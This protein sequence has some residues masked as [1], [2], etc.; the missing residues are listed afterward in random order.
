LKSLSGIKVSAATLTIILGDFIP[1]T[2]RGLSPRKLH[3]TRFGQPGSL[4]DRAI[5]DAYGKLPLIFEVNRGQTDSRVKF[6]S[7]GRGYSLFL[8]SSEAV[9]SLH[10]SDPSS[11]PRAR[12][13][14]APAKQKSLL[15][16]PTPIGGSVVRIKLIGANTKAQVSGFDE[17][18]SKSN[19]FIGNYPKN[20]RINV[21]NYARVKYA[22]VYS[23]V[24]LVYYGNQRQLEYD[25]VL[26]AK[27]DPR[28][29]ELDF[30]G[31]NRLW[32]D[33]DGNLIVSIAG[34]EIIEHKPLIYQ[35]INGIR[36]QVAGGY[37]LKKGQTVGFK[38]ARYDNHRGLTIDP[39]LVYST[40]LG[41]SNDDFGGGVAVDS[42]GNAYV[43]GDTFSTDFPTTPRAFQTTLRGAENGWCLSLKS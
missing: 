20:W 17:L 30:N 32:L 23:G 43:A 13:G 42:A 34:G 18:S 12:L 2:L 8:T 14:E 22:S 24:D 38:L 16:K 39:G 15:G 28:Q 7:R 19:Y 9:L 35:D 33:T 11:K 6:L 10:K 25:F 31:A 3:R 5:E 29:I 21:P 40:Y 41:G 37:E 4:S 27:A 36:R 1:L 26:A